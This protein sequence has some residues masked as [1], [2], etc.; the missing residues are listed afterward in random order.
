MNDSVKCNHSL[1][2][3]SGVN[4]LLMYVLKKN[5]AEVMVEKLASGTSSTCAH[6]QVHSTVM[7]PAVPIKELTPLVNSTKIGSYDYLS[8]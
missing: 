8:K 7:Y 2:V 5:M 4:V 1:F 6:A 3:L